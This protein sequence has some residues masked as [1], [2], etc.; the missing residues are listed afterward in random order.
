MTQEEE[1]LRKKINRILVEAYHNTLL[2]EETSKKN[3]RS[4]L[5][6]RDRN[7]LEFLQESRDGYT[8]SDLADYLRLSRPSATETVKKLEKLE[9]VERYRN[10][11]VRDDR[12]K[13]VRITQRGRLICAIQ[14]QYRNGITDNVLA[15]LNEEE[16][17]AF[18][19]GMV[20][21]SGSFDDEVKLIENRR[22]RK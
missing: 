3:T 13:S 5:S 16:R 20:A 9:L 6:F 17:K 22:K 18:Y 14:R 15:A 8:V 21:L 2:L 10:P 11:D 1:I 12:K 19:K 7:A 4:R